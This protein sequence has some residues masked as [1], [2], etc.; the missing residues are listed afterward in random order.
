MN[1]RRTIG[2]RTAEV[3]AEGNQVPPHAPVEGVAM[4]VNPVGLTDAKVR[5]SLA[6]MAHSITM[7]AQSMTYQVNGKNV[8]REKPSVRSTTDG[9]RDVTRMNPSICIGSKTSED[10]QEFVNEVH[11]IFVAMG[12]TDTEKAELASYQLKYFAQT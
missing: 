6:Q 12:A 11:K 3:V 1:T 7:Q 5:I 10:P 9:L 4:P 2:Q 8:Q